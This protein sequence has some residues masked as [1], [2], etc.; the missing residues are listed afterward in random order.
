MKLDL[1]T[2]QQDDSFYG[3]VELVCTIKSFDLQA[4]RKRYLESRKKKSGKIGSVER[5][6]IAEGGVVRLKIKEGNRF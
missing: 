5:R 2:Y 3:E 4:I 1:S 6:E